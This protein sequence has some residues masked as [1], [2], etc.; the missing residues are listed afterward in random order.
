M[1]LAPQHFQAQNRYFEDSLRAAVESLWFRP[2]G[3]AGCKLDAEALRN[4]T[5]A[6]VHARGI[7]EDGLCFHAPDCDP[8]PPPL[9]IADR[10]PPTSD[11]LTIC[12]AAPEFRPGGANCAPPDVAPDSHRY[13][14]EERLVPDDNTGAADRQVAFGRKNL[15]LFTAEDV[16]SDRVAL[17][18]ARVLRNGAGGFVYDPDFIPPLL[19]IAASEALMVR[20]RRLIEILDEK[21]A[22][23]SPSGDRWP[24][25]FSTRNIASF[26]LLHAINSGLVALRHQWVS[27]RGHPEELFLEMS[28]LGGALCTFASDS[29]PRSLPSYDHHRLSDCFDALDRHIREHLNAV[30][31]ANC[32]SIPLQTSAPY[33]FEGAVA[34]SRVFGRAEW[35]LGIRAAIGQGALITAAP[36]L[37]KVC[38]R[39]FVGELVRRALPG[40]ALKHLPVPPPAIPRKVET[41][42]FA[43]G[44]MGPA[45]DDIVQT[46]AV[47]IYVPGEF[48]QAELEL[49]VVLDA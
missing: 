31:P 10:F 13:V 47:G 33:F 14:A 45:W 26:W 29:H 48:P 42:Y 8:L 22:S 15:A 30:L 32:L 40:L 2:Y 41:Q 3:L 6:V 38:S 4:G 7:L 36:Q 44:R 39:R 18:I 20:V 16:P 43:I 12:L 24:D 11:R 27:K 19:Q 1:Y 9:L 25:D 5:V 46:K 23:L 21:S 37:I 17:P 34:D 49:S 35:V 28:R